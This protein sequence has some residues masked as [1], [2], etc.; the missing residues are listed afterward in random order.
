MIEVVNADTQVF[1][2]L[3]VGTRTGELALDFL[4]VDDAAGLHVDEEHFSRLQTPLLDDM[5]LGYGQH[6]RLGRHNDQIVVGHDVTRRAQAVAI[7]RGADLASIGKGD[8]GRAVPRLHHRGV[9]LVEGAAA[10]VHERVLFPGLGDHHHHGVR[11]RVARHQQQLKAVV[12][13]GGIALSG[14]D[15]RPELLQIGAEHRRRH[16]A[17]ARA[18]PVVVALDGVDLA[19]V[20]HQPVGV[21][22]RPLGEGVGGKPLVHQRQRR[23]HARVFEV[24]VILAHLI[25][26]QQALVHNGAR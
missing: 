9:V 6:A 23:H 1:D 17:F 26:Q 5:A 12:E 4:V 3:T 25:G 8:R 18:H 14:V 13:A 21:R 19:V 16:G 22:Q 20:R 7:E 11:Q 2:P 24:F 15:Q 10:R